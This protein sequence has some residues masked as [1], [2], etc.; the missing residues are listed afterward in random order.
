[1]AEFTIN[2]FDSLDFYDLS[3]IDGYDVPMKLQAPGTWYEEEREE[4]EGEGRR[5]DVRW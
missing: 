2:S 5:Q 3:E 1:L 4:M